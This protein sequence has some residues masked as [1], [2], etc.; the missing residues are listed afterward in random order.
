MDESYEWDN[1]YVPV[2]PMDPKAS[3]SIAGVNRDVTTRDGY[4]PELHLKQKGMK[5]NCFYMYYR[6]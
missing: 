2:H 5:N 4:R 6:Q 1:A 3:M